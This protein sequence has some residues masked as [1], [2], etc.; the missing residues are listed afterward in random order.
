MPMI[1]KSYNLHYIDCVFSHLNNFDLHSNYT[2]FKCF[3][4]YQARIYMYLRKNLYY[5][6][7]AKKFVSM[8]LQY[9]INNISYVTESSFMLLLFNN[10][11]F[12]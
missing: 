8:S 9:D 4:K 11:S 2:Y 6:I 3:N 12:V 10:F 7:R 5:K 1:D